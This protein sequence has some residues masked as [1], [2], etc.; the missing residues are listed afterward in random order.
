MSTAFVKRPERISLFVFGFSMV[1]HGLAYLMLFTPRLGQGIAFPLEYQVLI[2]GCAACS[3]VSLVIVSSAG[4]VAAHVVRAVFL[5]VVCRIAGPANLAVAGM[6]LLPYLVETTLYLAAPWSLAINGI[7]IAANLGFDI[8]RVAQDPTL[9]Q[10]LGLCAAYALYIATTVMGNQLVSYRETI[11]A[12]TRRI[13]NLTTANLAFQDHAEHVESESTKRERN[14]ITRELHDITAYALTNIAMTMNAAKVLFTDNPR[15]LPDLFETARRQAEDA[16]QETRTTLY[17]LRSVEDRKLKGL[18]AFVRMAR[19]FQAATGVTV[20]IN[21]GNVPF[22]LGPVV[23][24]MIYRL[25]QQGLTNAFRHGKADTVRVNLWRADA[26][27]RVTISDNGKGGEE[28]QEGI[29]MQGMRERL[30]MVGGS[31]EAHNRP[32]GFELSASIP[33]EA[34]DIDE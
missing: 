7:V 33:V 15:E 25:I 20:Q 16:L 31:V 23:D 5:F 13:A 34:C 4:F 1:F 6:L 11:V 18:H 12:H 28:L 17:L 30:G 26:E 24:A 9:E 14:R 27:I 29:G 21:Y 2:V 19:E 3:L 8:L 32:S 10:I 22:S